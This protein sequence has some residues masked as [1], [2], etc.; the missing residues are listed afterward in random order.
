MWDFS[1]KIEYTV[2]IDES[3][4]YTIMTVEN[5]DQKE[6]DFTALLHTYLNVDI[7]SMTVN[8]FQQEKCSNSLT[9]EDFVETSDAVKIEANVDQIYKGVEKDQI[10]SSNLG[11]VK[12]SRKGLPDVVFWNPWIEKAKAMG[13]FNDDGYKN[14]VC[15]EP[16]YVAQR[17]VLK[18]SEKWTGSQW[19]SVL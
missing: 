14:M 6:F 17:K 1:F 13:D 10:V 3:T 11:K 12:V 2:R 15:V 9:G 19:L 5:T 8:G 4:L 7:Q 16:G 18:P